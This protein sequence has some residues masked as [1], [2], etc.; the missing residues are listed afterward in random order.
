MKKLPK[1]K[2]DELINY[3]KN[4]PEILSFDYEILPDGENIS[5]I[6]TFSENIPENHHKATAHIEK[7]LDAKFQ[8]IVILQ[9]VQY[10]NY[11]FNK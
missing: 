3:L 2:E 1:E 5:I 10:F 4:F 11:K 6:T 8:Q 9:N 7:I